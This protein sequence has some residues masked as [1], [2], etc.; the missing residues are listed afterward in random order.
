VL[1]RAAR[2]GITPHAAAEAMAR[3][4]YRALGGRL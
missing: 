2:D 4:R 1:A 3:E